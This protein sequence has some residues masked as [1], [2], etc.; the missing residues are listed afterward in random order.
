MVRDFLFLFFTFFFIGHALAG[1]SA[2][3]YMDTVINTAL[4]NVIRSEKL[5]P[6][7]L[8]NFTF[9]YKDKKWGVTVH[10]KAEYSEGSLNGL[11][12]IKRYS[13]CDGPK[14]I[15][16]STTINCTLVFQ[17]LETS[18][19]GKV[20]YGV[21]PKVTIH[22]KGNLQLVNIK[23][24]IVKSF[25]ERNPQVKSFSFS[26]TGSMNTDFTGLGPLNKQT[27][28]LQD[29]YKSAVGTEILNVIKNRFQ[30]ALNL[31]VAS[32]PMPVR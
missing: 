12:K 27:K 5:E 15:S 4:Q 31:A 19:K 16:S 22:A 24:G 32:V 28:V 26:T 21:L 2:N 17:S 1:Q 25:S 23:V 3:L 18:H 20:K 10:G 13:E 8:S 6:T 9:D 14:N 7:H 29:N 11:S 30:Y